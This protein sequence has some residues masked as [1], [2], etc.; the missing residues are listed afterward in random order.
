MTTCK[1]IHHAAAVEVGLLLHVPL[2]RCLW[3]PEII[4]CTTI[5]KLHACGIVSICDVY[6][7]EEKCGK[8]EGRG[9]LGKCRPRWQDNMKLDSLI[10]VET[11]GLFLSLNKPVDLTLN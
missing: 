10:C 7:G 4:R 1:V 3:S 11:K 6:G 2:H 8:P 5:V 9:S